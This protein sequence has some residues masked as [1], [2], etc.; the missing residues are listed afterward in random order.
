MAD[1]SVGIMTNARSNE[2]TDFLVIGAGLAGLAFAR[3]VTEQGASVRLLDKGRVVGGRAATR[4]FGTTRVD[5]GAQFFTARSFEF[6]AIVEQGLTEGWIRTWYR[7]IPEWREGRLHIRPSGHARYAC[8]E[9]I[10]A[11]PKFL[12]RDLQ[13][14]TEAEVSV[15]SREDQG[16]RAETK[17][18]RTFFGTNLILNLPPVQLLSLAGKLIAPEAAERIER[19]SLEPCWAFLGQLERDLA[20]DWPALE[21]TE[22]PVFSWIARDHTKRPAGASPTLV[23]HASAAW[24]RAHLEASQAEVEP[25]LR[26]ALKELLGPLTLT[27]SQTHRWR[28]AKPETSFGESFFWDGTRRIAACGDWCAGGRVEGA[29]LSGLRLGQEVRL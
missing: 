25:L 4:R 14:V 20:V 15:L 19:V 5:H 2:T 16:Y 9:G 8:P 26:A 13:I 3:Q 7:S 24:T 21:L 12:A 22:H 23:A 29:F 11:L 27:Q 18:G 10:S 17:D 1:A 28:Y 6:Q